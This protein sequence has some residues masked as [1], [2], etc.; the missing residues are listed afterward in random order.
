MASNLVLLPYSYWADPSRSRALSG[1]QIFIGEVDKDPETFPI[2]V[3]YIEE[4]GTEVPAVQPLIIGPGG[5]II[6]NGKVV[7]IGAND[8]YSMRVRDKH[9]AQAYNVPNNFATGGATKEFVAEQID[10]VKDDIES[11]RVSSNAK[12]NGHLTVAEAKALPAEDISDG[13]IFYLKDRA[14]TP[15]EVVTGETPDEKAIIA[16]NTLPFQFKIINTGPIDIVRLGADTTGVS[17]A[18]E[19]EQ[20]AIDSDLFGSMYDSKGQFLID[21]SVTIVADTTKSG[22]GRYDNAPN[23]TQFNIDNVDGYV[24]S[25]NAANI[26][27]ENFSLKGGDT[28]NSR[29]VYAPNNL[30]FSMTIRSVNFFSF[31][32]NPVYFQNTDQIRIDNCWFNQN[33][34]P[35][36]FGTTDGLITNTLFE[37]RSSDLSNSPTSLIEVGVVDGDAGD[38]GL[39][40]IDIQL[41]RS[42]IGIRSRARL[43]VNGLNYG[44]VRCAV[45]LEDGIAKLDDFRPTPSGDEI[46]AILAS[47]CTHYSFTRVPLDGGGA[48]ARNIRPKYLKN[49]NTNRYPT[50]WSRVDAV[51]PINFLTSNNAAYFET[52]DYLWLVNAGAFLPEVSS[53]PKVD[54]G[55][56]TSGSYV[57]ELI[58][59]GVGYFKVGTGGSVI[60]SSQS[61]GFKVDRKCA[62]T[63]GTLSAYPGAAQLGAVFAEFNVYENLY[64][65]GSFDDDLNDALNVVSGVATYDTT[66]T[67]GGFGKSLRVTSGEAYLN[68]P[69]AAKT[70][71]VEEGVYVFIPVGVTLTVSTFSSYT[72]FNDKDILDV[73]GDNQWHLY[74]TPLIPG[75]QVFSVTLKFKFNGTVY[76]DDAACIEMVVD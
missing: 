56:L 70:K 41:E 63:S 68:I 12:F 6:Y 64:T 24:I 23:T 72:P 53:S 21:S 52:D 17:S 55:N 74:R 39:K 26:L 29:G 42:K 66:Q 40:F 2:D 3:F 46:I 19:F 25:P 13:Y 16:H 76:F 28:A 11:L 15:F 9:N 30:F 14:F 34:G 36:Y 71:T 31:G 18:V 69:T 62:N 1:G 43:D 44:R 51:T 65:S 35:A 54:L 58:N 47:D 50:T 22:E 32:S 10:L 33:A 75:T 49:T 27:F 57:L 45:Y 73:E 38:G 5:M 59:N 61:D 60:N 48:Y 20:Y 7:Q 67:R 37:G 8:N 4:D